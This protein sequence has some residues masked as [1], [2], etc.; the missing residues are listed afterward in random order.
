MIKTG[1]FWVRSIFNRQKGD[2][3]SDLKK[4]L[5]ELKKKIKEERTESAIRENEFQDRNKLLQLQNKQ[6][7]EE[8]DMLGPQYADSDSCGSIV[9]TSEGKSNRLFSPV[10]IVTKSDGDENNL[11]AEEILRLC[12]GLK[13]VSNLAKEKDDK[14]LMASMQINLLQQELE[15]M[16]SKLSSERRFKI[17]SIASPKVNKKT[18]EKSAKI[19][20]LL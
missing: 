16:F 19:L 17:D 4:E 15:S 10:N 1:K 11:L 18:F 13:T 12:D 7:I 3:M 9:D 2:K 20:R 5:L 6:L 14:L 8:M